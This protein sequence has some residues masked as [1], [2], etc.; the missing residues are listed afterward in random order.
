[1]FK[2]VRLFGFATRMSI[3]YRYAN[4]LFFKEISVMYG[5]LTHF[6]D[7]YNNSMKSLIKKWTLIEENAPRFRAFYY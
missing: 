1:M 5:I 6:I 4:F 3:L 2:F 7:F